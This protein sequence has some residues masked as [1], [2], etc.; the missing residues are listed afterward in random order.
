MYEL[1]K[2]KEMIFATGILITC[3]WLSHATD[4]HDVIDSIRANARQYTKIN[5][6]ICGPDT[7]RI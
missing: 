4:N 5:M 7:I 3:S 2:H 1:M 6:V